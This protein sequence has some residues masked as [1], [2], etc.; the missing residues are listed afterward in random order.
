MVRASVAAGCNES[1]RARQPSAGWS[2]PPHAVQRFFFHDKPKSDPWTAAKHPGLHT[3]STQSAYL[4]A[5]SIQ[6]GATHSNASWRG[7]GFAQ[8]RRAIRFGLTTFSAAAYTLSRFSPNS[9]PTAR[10]LEWRC[11]GRCSQWQRQYML[12]FA[13]TYWVGLSLNRWCPPGVCLEAIFNQ[14]RRSGD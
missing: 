2:P 13:I 6:N 9:H 14:L 7:V 10:F 12:E 4:L 3:T 11:C 5:F 8:V 1:K